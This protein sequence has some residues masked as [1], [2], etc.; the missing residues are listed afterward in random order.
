MPSEDK[1]VTQQIID[2]HVERVLGGNGL[3]FTEVCGVHDQSTPAHFL[4]IGDDKYVP[5]LKKLV[6]AI[7][8]AG[9]KSRIQLWQGGMATASYQK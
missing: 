6:D 2:Y 4:S 9:G 3:N 7:H 5:E 8:S 1:Y